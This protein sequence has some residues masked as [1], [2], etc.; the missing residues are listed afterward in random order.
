MKWLGIIYFITQSLI[1]FGQETN[2]PLYLQKDLKLYSPDLNQITDSLSLNN[3][4]P[5]FTNK[6]IKPNITTNIKPGTESKAE[7]A[8]R[9]KV[10]FGSYADFQ[11][12]FL[13]LKLKDEPVNLYLKKIKEDLVAVSNTSSGGGIVFTGPITAIYNA[14]SK[15]VESQRKHQELIEYAPKQKI[16][17]AKYNTEKVQYWTGLKNEELTQFVLFCDFKDSFLLRVS[18]YE[19]I[20]KIR[21]KLIEFKAKSDSCNYQN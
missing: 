6:Y 2:T 11:K 12:K 20:A 3:I 13:A 5:D 14:F 8:R 17:H 10:L 15:E 18:D 16:I 21:N 19:L 1:L 4:Q 9:L 7:E